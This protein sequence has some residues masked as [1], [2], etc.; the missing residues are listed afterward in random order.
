MPAVRAMLR[1]PESQL[2]QSSEHTWSDFSALCGE[3]DDFSLFIN[4]S[5]V[6]LLARIWGTQYHNFLAKTNALKIL[7][8]YF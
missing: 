2:V 5:Y 6:L 8:M 1:P 4:S 7:N 3:E